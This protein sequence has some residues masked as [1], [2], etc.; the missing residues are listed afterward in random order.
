MGNICHHDQC[1]VDGDCKA[2]MPAGATVAICAPAG[3]LNQGANA[4]CVYGGCR[5]EADCT[6]HP[7]GRCQYGLADTG[8]ACSVRY[9]LFCAYPSDPCLTAAGCSSLMICV[10]NDDYQGRRCGK[11]LPMYP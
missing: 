8:G 2:Q 6:K 3:A 7:D 5:T 10:P 1:R 4:G 11:G 9:V